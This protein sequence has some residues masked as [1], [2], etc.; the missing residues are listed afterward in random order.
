[1]LKY[2]HFKY[3][4]QYFHLNF[5]LDVF[6]NFKALDWSFIC[7]NLNKCLVKWPPLEI[8]ALVMMDT[9]VHLLF[10]LSDQNENFFTAHF[11]ELMGQKCPNEIL[12][13]PIKN[14]SQY[15]NTYKYIYRNPV[16][17][18][19][20]LMCESYAYSSLYQLL[21]QGPQHLKVI[22]AMGLIQNPRK[23]LTWLNTESN[24]KDSKLKDV[25][26]FPMSNITH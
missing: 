26:T 5:D 19:L 11:L 3:P 10:R 17:A 1:M 18:G 6:P 8:H 7:H 15:L 12:V 24:Y 2:S 20:S 9:H 13:E 25:T 4:H 21:G 22:D 23:V 14:Y 16:E